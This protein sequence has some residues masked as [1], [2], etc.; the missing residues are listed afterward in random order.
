MPIIVNS[1]GA[2]HN[3]DVAHSTSVWLLPVHCRYGGR[4]LT[5]HS[6]C[7]GIERRA[8]LAAEE[9]WRRTLRKKTGNGIN[10]FVVGL[11][12]MPTHMLPANTRMMQMIQRYPEVAIFY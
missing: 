4:W 10:T 3:T 1:D 12:T 8:L 6:D 9:L 7:N 11:T 2:M 5:G